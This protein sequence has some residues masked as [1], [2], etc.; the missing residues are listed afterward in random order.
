MGMPKHAQHVAPQC[1]AHLRK[2]NGKKFTIWFCV[3]PEGHEGEHRGMRKRWPRGEHEL[4]G[5]APEVDGSPRLDGPA[6]V[7][8]TNESR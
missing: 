2:S 6:L 7:P 3:L 1:P 5:N 8:Q 4:P